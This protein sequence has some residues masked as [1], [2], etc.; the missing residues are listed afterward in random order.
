MATFFL[1]LYLFAHRLAAVIVG[2]ILRIALRKR[3]IPDGTF[4]IHMGWFSYRGPFDGSQIVISNLMWRNP[5][6]F[7]SDRQ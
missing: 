1:L 3:L 7:R 4:T 6:L 2:L 5:P